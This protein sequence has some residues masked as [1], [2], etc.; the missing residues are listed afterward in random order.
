MQPERPDELEIIDEETLILEE[1]KECVPE[2]AEERKADIVR[3][4]N[5][6]LPKQ[7]QKAKSMFIRRYHFH[8]TTAEIGQMFDTSE[9]YVR[10]VL[11][12]TRRKLKHFLK[13][14]A[15]NE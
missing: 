6:F 11:S 8:E 12:R 1:L 7:G 2:G 13:E 4:L 9:A 15:V 14:H 3:L 5:E 10:T